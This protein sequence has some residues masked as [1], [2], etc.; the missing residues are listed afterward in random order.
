M[1]QEIGKRIKNIRENMNMTKEDFAKSIGISGQYLG[2]VERGGSCLSVEKLKS[3]C[4]LTN[5]SADY[6]LFGKDKDLIDTTKKIL[7]EFSD[8]QIETG[9]KTLKKLALFIKSIE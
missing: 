8:T 5:L 3:L 9:C 4:D 1:K 7:S 2:I 6:I